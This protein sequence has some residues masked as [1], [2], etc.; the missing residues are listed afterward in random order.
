MSYAVLRREVLDLVGAPKLFFD[1][2]TADLSRKQAPIP[3]FQTSVPGHRLYPAERPT[4]GTKTLQATWLH[5]KNIIMNERSLSPEQM[6]EQHRLIA[7]IESINARMEVLGIE[8]E[9]L[10]EQE[11]ALDKEREQLLEKVLEG[12]TVGEDTL[13]LQDLPSGGLTADDFEKLG[14]E[15]GNTSRKAIE[16]QLESAGWL[17]LGARP[18]PE[19]PGEWD[20]FQGEIWVKK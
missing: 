20:E 13:V 5:G 15:G 3:R 12:G 14:L 17:N 11:D 10:R 7:E 9:Q 2:P 4:F 1:H 6:P 16:E 8:R 18:K 19:D